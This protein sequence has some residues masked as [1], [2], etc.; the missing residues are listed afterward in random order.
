MDETVN[1][2]LPYI[3]PSQA[4][5]HVTHNEALRRLDA[6]VQLSVRS[7]ALGEAP[8]QPS[9]GER[10][11]VAGPAIGA[12][13][14]REGQIAN[15]VDGAWMFHQPRKG[16]LAWV[17]EEAQLLLYHE[18]GWTPVADRIAA[19]ITAL[20]NIGMLGVNASADAANRL[21]V[22][23]PASLFSHAGAGHQLKV[24]KNAPG[25]TASILFQ[26]GFSGR[27]EFGLTGDDDWHVK[28]SSDGNAWHEVLV[29]RKADGAVELPSAGVS[30]DRSL[31]PN[32]LPDSGRFSGSNQ[33]SLTS[34]SAVAPG[35]LN[36]FN[37]S[38][39]SFPA[40][41]VH[42]NTTYGGAAGE[43]DPVIDELIQKIYG[44]AGLR[45]GPEFW[46]MNVAAGDGT[47]SPYTI[48]ADNFFRA[49]ICASN[50]RPAR[51]TTGLF[52]RC[53]SGKLALRPMNGTLHR[54]TRD[55]LPVEMGTAD[56]IVGPSDG[57]V[58]FEMQLTRSDLA[59]EQSDMAINLTAG[60]E[61][62]VA[63]PRVVAGWVSIGYGGAAVLPCDRIFGS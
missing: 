16:W 17:E 3:L 30:L 60:G 50:P 22:A 36:A 20:Q 57:W 39:V 42:N 33:A 44:P 6:L 15:F 49:T 53:S 55:G 28:V 10:H 63:L 8:P 13:A 11:I 56:V 47:A 38:A 58:Y 32:L 21:A 34:G 12:W 46:Y 40:K 25:D 48:G 52:A 24:N 19:V 2:A 51:Y 43:L 35:Y 62:Q 27:A 37:G 23:S 7:R 9:E 18:G 61:G 59:Y 29:A 41:F 45:Y 1:L 4:Q 5:K 14:G 26:T 31:F 54:L